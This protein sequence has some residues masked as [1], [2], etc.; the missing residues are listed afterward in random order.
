MEVTWAEVSLVT[1]VWYVVLT[2]RDLWDLAK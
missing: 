2:I 1:V